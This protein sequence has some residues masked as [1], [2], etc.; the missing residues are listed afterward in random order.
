MIIFYLQRLQ[1]RSDMVKKGTVEDA[2]TAHDKNTT[3][4]EDM[5][6]VS[7]SVEVSNDV[8]QK[9]TTTNDEWFELWKCNK[10]SYIFDKNYKF[11]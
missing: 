3:A 5:F 10:N 4:E 9:D 11:L 1:K 8:N 6:E 7:S 2:S